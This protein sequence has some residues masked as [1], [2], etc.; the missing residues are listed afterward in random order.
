MYV[1]TRELSTGGVCLGS[2][3]LGGMHPKFEARLLLLG[4]V[5]P[6]NGQR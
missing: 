6:C 3:G 4:M 5:Y 1:A 2:V